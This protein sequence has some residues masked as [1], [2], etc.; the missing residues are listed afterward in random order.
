[1]PTGAP[2]RRNAAGRSS[3]ARGI[4]ADR[5][6]AARNCAD[7]SSAAR[8]IRSLVAVVVVATGTLGLTACAADQGAFEKAV[9]AAVLA[10]GPNIADT[11]LSFSSGPAGRGFWLRLYLDDTGVEASAES[12][13]AAL[14]A[15]YLASPSEPTGI[16]LDI[17][18]A[19]KPDEVELTTGSIPIEDAADEAGLPWADNEIHLSSAA[20]DERYGPWQETR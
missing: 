10:A 14:E 1:M 15:A 16:T 7:R 17:A 9:P 4:R 2:P 13:D 20:L 19:P 12:I 18:A 6:G 3:A 8:G 11:Y 5:N